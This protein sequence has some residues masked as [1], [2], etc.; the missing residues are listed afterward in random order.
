MDDDFELRQLSSEVLARSG[1]QVDLAADGHAAWQALQSQRYD[2]LITDNEM[3][4]V[5]GVELVKKLRTGGATLPVI[6]AS[7]CIPE[8]ELERH[9]WL[10][11]AATLMKPFTIE[12]LLQTVKQALHAAESRTPGPARQGFNE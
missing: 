1:Y 4:K 2:L 12:E 5:S 11:L 3:P 10:Q 8:E 9:P 7:A 6:M